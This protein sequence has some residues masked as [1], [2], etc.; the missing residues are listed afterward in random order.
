STPSRLVLHG[1][2][3]VLHFDTEGRLL[4]GLPPRHSASPTP[5]AVVPEV[6][7]TDGKLQLVGPACRRL[8]FKDITA[9]LTPG[10][11]VCTFDGKGLCVGCGDCTA[12]GW[13][14]LKNPG[15]SLTVRSQGNVAVT[16]QLLEALP[17]V[18]PTTWREVQADGLTPV[19]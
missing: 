18:S 16:Q 2:T 8:D 17:F 9:T 10:A 13:I 6:V 5:L 15:V 4:T 19:L 12:S 7:L 11:D 1:V 14:N 3:I